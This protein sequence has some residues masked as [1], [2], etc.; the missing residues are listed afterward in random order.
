MA[1][2]RSNATSTTI[3]YDFNKKSIFRRP[4]VSIS[5]AHSSLFEDSWLRSIVPLE[6]YTT[7]ACILIPLGDFKFKRG[8]RI[9]ILPQAYSDFLPPSPSSFFYIMTTVDHYQGAFFWK[10]PSF[11]QII[12]CEKY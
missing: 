3:S 2:R 5:R 7:T 4:G 8:D 10:I 1:L 6:F 11:S 12:L 9:P